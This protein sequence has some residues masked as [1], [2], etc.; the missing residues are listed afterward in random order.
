MSKTDT[1]VRVEKEVYKKLAKM[2]ELSGVS[3]KAYLA[4]LINKTYKGN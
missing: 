1:T 4:A 3:V 2:A